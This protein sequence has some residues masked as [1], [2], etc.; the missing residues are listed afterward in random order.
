MIENG[1]TV[2]DAGAFGNCPNLTGVTIPNTVT[3]IGRYTFHGTGLTG[4]AI[5][6]SATS[7]DPTAFANSG[8]LASL[9]VHSGNTTYESV[10]N[11]LI[12]KISR[13]LVLCPGGLTSV[14]IPDSVVSMG[15]NAFLGC[16][17]TSVTI[18]DSV[19]SIGNYA[20]AY[21]FSLASVTFTDA[22]PP[23]IGNY[24]FGETS[25]SAYPL[26]QI[27]VPAGSLAAYKAALAT[28][29]EQAGLSA[30]IIVEAAATAPV[31]TMALPASLT[32]KVGK[33]V[34]FTVKAEAD[35]DPVIYKWLRNAAERPIHDEIPGATGPSYTISSASL[36]DAGNYIVYAINTRTNEMKLTGGGS[37]D[38][39]VVSGSTPPPSNSSG[40]SGGSG[41]LPSTP[42][43]RSL[44]AGS[45][46]SLADAAK[47]K[48]KD[49]V[50]TTYNGQYTLKK[51]AL[52][53]LAGLQY[54]HD[55]MNGS[56]VQVRVAIDKPASI[57]KDILVSG[58]V[59]G[60]AVDNRKAFFEKRF[61]NKVRVIHLDQQ[62]DWGYPV[63]IAAKVDLTGFDTANLYFYSYNSKTNIC[64]RIGKPEYS[65]N[66]NGYL[67]FTTPYA[68]DIVVSEGPLDKK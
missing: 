8:S 67:W 13:I 40:S 41:G 66:K 63:R 10:D 59:Q 30:D 34:T 68:G 16:S 46:K 1:I 25:L 57:T 26:A 56:A 49:T 22:A 12:N 61:R 17:L 65:I 18:P 36:S 38:L 9:T 37:C 33:P 42:A 14:T 20:F 39:K 27:T 28:A 47:Q 15:D 52:A 43:L 54:A 19:T 5:P 44:D 55:T 60:G 51:N 4:I 50:R 2:I 3:S 24:I 58:Y 29:L 48:G 21:C 11:L 35:G 62:E 32:V 53:A 23:S 6:A 7:I 45:M 64:R 31:F